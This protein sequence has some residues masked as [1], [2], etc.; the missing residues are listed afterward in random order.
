MKSNSKLSGGNMS[1]DCDNFTYEKLVG[2]LKEVNK[3]L[4]NPL[5][6]LTSKSFGSGYHIVHGREKSFILVH[7]DSLYSDIARQHRGGSS[8][9]LGSDPYGSLTGRTFRGCPI[10]DIDRDDIEDLFDQRTRQTDQVVRRLTK[11]LLEPSEVDSATESVYY[12]NT[13]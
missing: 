10:I 9:F 13:I 7:P 4:P 11:A 6:F 12:Q 5:T 3:T 8:L 2:L 1:Q